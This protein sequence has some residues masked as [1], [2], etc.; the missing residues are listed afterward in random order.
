MFTGR[1]GGGLQ[2]EELPNPDKSFNPD[3]MITRKDSSPKEP[4][5]HQQTVTTRSQ[6]SLIS[7]SSKRKTLGRPRRPAS[8]ISPEDHPEFVKYLEEVV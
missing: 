8:L 3:M 2:H 7:S 6:L 5:R 1:F 4:K